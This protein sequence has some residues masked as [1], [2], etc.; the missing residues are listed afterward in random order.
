MSLVDLKTK[1][2]S[3]TLRSGKVVPDPQD[4]PAAPF[5][6]SIGN[7]DSLNNDAQK[8][9]NSQDTTTERSIAKQYDIRRERKNQPY[10]NYADDPELLLET[11]PKKG[12]PHT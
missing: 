12:R 11:A 7:K 1:D 4:G 6:E 5:H 3:T 2:E 9:S 10:T 8:D